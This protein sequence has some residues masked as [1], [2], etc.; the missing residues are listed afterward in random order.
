MYDKSSMRITYCNKCND[1]SAQQENH[2]IYI[3][4]IKN[5]EY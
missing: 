1:S 2:V 5:L 4:F 3:S